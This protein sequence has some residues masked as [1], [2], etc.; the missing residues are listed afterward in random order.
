GA[1]FTVSVVTDAQGRYSFPADKLEPGDY[2]ITIRATGYDL[3]GKPTAAVAA[4]KTANVD[5][6]LGKTKRLAAQLTNARWMASIPGS[7]EQKAPLLN[8]VGCHTLERIVRSSHDAE[9]WAQVVHRMMGYAAVSQPIKPQRLP[10]PER[11]GTPAQYAKFGEYLATINL[12]AN[13]TWE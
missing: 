6:K 11:A 3:A 12:S 10:D 5:L 9:E 8:C 13:P 2:A 4:E 1:K 7:E